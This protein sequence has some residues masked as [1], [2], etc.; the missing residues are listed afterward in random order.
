MYIIFDQPLIPQNITLIDNSTLN[1]T[2]VPNP[3]IDDVGKFNFTF[4][5]TKYDP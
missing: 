5:C 4:V 2:I 3:N 1:I